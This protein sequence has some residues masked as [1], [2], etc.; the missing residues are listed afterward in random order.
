VLL[1]PAFA[2]VVG[3]VGAIGAIVGATALKVGREIGGQLD[4]E[5]LLPM[6]PPY[7]PI[8]RFLYTKPELVAELTRKR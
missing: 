2:L 6:P 1:P 4:E 8:P 5:D 7:P 3:T